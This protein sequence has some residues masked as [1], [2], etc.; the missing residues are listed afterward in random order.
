MAISQGLNQTWEA[1]NE[2]VDGGT[3]LDADIELLTDIGVSRTVARKIVQRVQQLAGPATQE[4]APTT[5][6]HHQAGDEEED[7]QMEE[8]QGEQERQQQARGPRE[9]PRRPPAT[10]P[11]QLTATQGTRHPPEAPEGSRAARAAAAARPS[12]ATRRASEAPEASQ[13]TQG[14]RATRAASRGTFRTARTDLATQATQSPL[15]KPDPEQAEEEALAWEEEQQEEQQQQQ[16]RTRRR[17]SARQQ[18]QEPLEDGR[19]EEMEEAQQEEGMETEAEEESETQDESGGAAPRRRGRHVLKEDPE[20]LDGGGGAAGVAVQEHSLPLTGRRSARTAGRQQDEQQQEQQQ[21][22]AGPSG[23]GRPRTRR[24]QQQQEEAQ[25]RATQ[26]ELRGRTMQERQRRQE[27]EQESEE[28]EEAGG[29]QQQADAEDEEDWGE[30]AVEDLGPEARSGQYAKDWERRAKWG[31]LEIFTSMPVQKLR[32]LVEGQEEWSELAANIMR[33]RRKVEGESTWV[34]LEKAKSIAP[35]LVNFIMTGDPDGKANDSGPLHQRAIKELLKDY[36]D[37]AVRAYV[38]DVLKPRYQNVPRSQDPHKLM[39]KLWHY[40]RGPAN[41]VLE[42]LLGSREL[43]YEAILG[44]D[45]EP[46][47]AT[48]NT[49]WPK[50]WQAIEAGKLTLVNQEEVLLWLI[51][52]NDLSTHPRVRVS[53]RLTRQPGNRKLRVSIYQIFSTS[54]LSSSLISGTWQ[55]KNA[56]TEEDE[57]VAVD[58]RFL[59]S[60]LDGFDGSPF[61]EQMDRLTQEYEATE[62]EVT[63]RGVEG[64]LSVDAP[65]NL[66]Q[67][68]KVMACVEDVDRGE[69][70]EFREECSDAFLLTLRPYQRRSLAHMLREERALGGSS[71]NLWVKLNLPE[72]PDVQCYV[73]PILHQI[74]SST[75]RIEAEQWVNANGG[76][77]WIALE[78]FL[79]TYRAGGAG[80]TLTAGTHIILC[81]PTLNPSFE[82]QAIGRSHRMGQTKPLTVTRMLMLGTI[83]EKVA[84]FVER[85]KSEV[86]GDPQQQLE[87]TMMETNQAANDETNKLTIEEL[88]DFIYKIPDEE[89]E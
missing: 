73:S 32:E 16:R 9:P 88:R 55:R 65:M 44:A 21:E 84:E 18:K 83:E 41:D 14:T 42:T 12:R 56:D 49:A 71:R 78:V 52:V 15:I 69:P 35:R 27:E 62:N 66:K 59:L 89:D 51:H 74:R 29:I 53:A 13:A 6:Q 50:V 60:M 76:A 19:E 2:L 85:Q 40:P 8:D 63:A 3:L 47:A 26:R 54:T 11:T 58:L 39:W 25:L 17:L 72:H 1:N 64:E 24:Q 10:Q 75:S 68:D 23:S 87:S 37:D 82:K 20:Q 36:C 48:G 77:G 7:E 30:L 46:N 61:M 45:L 5:Q 33:V 43:E 86:E 28:E 81:E 31:M 38:E 79:L 70:A 80:I 57:L 4:L 34:E 22:E 67:F